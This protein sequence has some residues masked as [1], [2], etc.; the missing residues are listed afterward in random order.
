MRCINA[1]LENFCSPVSVRAGM[2]ASQTIFISFYFMD[3]ARMAMD[4]FSIIMTCGGCSAAC[5]TPG[6]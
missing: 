5:V 6:T 3:V 2:W 4:T 1:T